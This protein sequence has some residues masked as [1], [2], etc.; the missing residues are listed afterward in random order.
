[1]AVSEDQF[2]PLAELAV[3]VGVNLRPGQ[4]L[5]VHAEAAD[6][7][8][9]RAVSRAAYAAGAK[10]VH[11]IFRDEACDRITL[12]AAPED[13]LRAFPR[14]LADAFIREAEGGA[15]FL[16]IFGGDPHAFAGVAPDRIGLAMRAA[17][18][19]MQPY[20]E[21]TMSH[22]VPW[23]IVAAP[24]PE[25]AKL[26]FPDLPAQEAEAKLWEAIV[27]TSRADGPD[28]VAAWQSHMGNLQVRRNWL[29]DLAIE[30][31]HY[32]SP[33]T[34]LR[35]ELPRTHRWV[36]AGQER[37]LG[38]VTAPNI[39]TEEAFTLPLRT[40]VDGTVRSTKSLSFMGQQIDGIAL[41]FEAGRIAEFHAEV[42]EDALRQ[43]IE[44]DEGSRYLG[45]VALVPV[46]SPIS[47]SG[48]L[49]HNTLF[50]ENA[51]CHL[52]IGAAYPTCLTDGRD[53]HSDEDL[54]AKGGNASHMHVDF[55]IGSAE[56]DIDATTR[57]GKEVAIF[58]RGKWASPVPG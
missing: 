30:R 6:A 10:R 54:L 4:N 52:A 8:P 22:K 28:P 3:K 37:G 51:S 49:F 13:G 58:R 31:L 50:D 46:D 24:S 9:V 14:W 2:R 18:E 57:E 7:A 19:A 42:G 25:W 41:R 5:V 39:P 44:T 1:M 35:I 40:G 33:G 43:V 56:L 48:I 27:R 12:E 17:Q 15:A 11:V 20:R 55:M 38:Y 45:E 36:A 23:S 21:M 32:R 53:V 16:S 34:D 26:V 47:Q 29:N